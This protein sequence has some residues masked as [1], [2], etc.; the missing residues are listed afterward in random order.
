MFPQSVNGKGT[1]TIVPLDI[2]FFQ[3]GHRIHLRFIFQKVEAGRQGIDVCYLVERFAIGM[4][5]LNDEG[6]DGVATADPEYL[7]VYSHA[8]HNVADVFSRLRR[9]HDGHMYNMYMICFV[10]AT[11]RRRGT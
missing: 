6:I 8:I 1:R 5:E 9:G 4:R 3:I 11:I 7:A 2:A 10:G